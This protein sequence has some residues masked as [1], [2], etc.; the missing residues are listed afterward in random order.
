MNHTNAIELYKCFYTLIYQVVFKVEAT[1]PL[2]DASIA[3]RSRAQISRIIAL[4]SNLFELPP[5]A[6][7]KYQT[8]RY[9]TDFIYKAFS[10]MD[11][12]ILKNCAA[13]RPG[14]KAMPQSC[15]LFSIT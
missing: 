3:E 1:V 9:V 15:T 4:F 7:N 11:A 13:Y 2:T 12:I 14:N 6:R 10:K 8:K 5:R